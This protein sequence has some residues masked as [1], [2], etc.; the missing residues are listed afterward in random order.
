MPVVDIV[1]RQLWRELGGRLMLDDLLSEG[2]EGLLAAARSFEPSLGV[3][4]R[5][6]ANYR[7]RGA[8]LDGVRRS[9]NLPRAVYEQLRSLEAAHTT[10]EAFGEEGSA[11]LVSSSEEADDR[12]ASYL[13]SIATA[14][15]MG[16]LATPTSATSGEAVDPHRPADE[17][18]AREETVHMVR[19]AMASL[20]ERERHMIQRHYFDDVRL[21]QAAA[22]LGLSKSWGSRLHARAIESITRYMKRSRAMP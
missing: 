3:P 9:S 8:V 12:L 19:E 7:V 10:G 15:A 16:L 1:A 18:L 6:W 11:R 20:P 17:L 21:D 4:F 22:E 5:R 13:A 2:R 14:V